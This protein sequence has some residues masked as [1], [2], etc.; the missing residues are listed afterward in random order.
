MTYAA[1]PIARAHPPDGS[2]N[3]RY[4]GGRRAPALRRRRAAPPVGAGA[5]RF[6]PAELQRAWERLGTGDPV[7]GLLARIAGDEARDARLPMPAH[8]ASPGAL[9]RHR[10]TL[11]VVG[12][13]ALLALLP[14]LLISVFGGRLT[15][16]EFVKLTDWRELPGRSSSTWCWPRCCGPST[17]GSP[18]SSSTSSPAS[19]RAASS[20]RPGRAGMTPDGFLQGV[21]ATLPRRLARGPVRLS[22]GAWLAALAAAASVATL[23]VWP[24]TALPPFDRLFAEGDLYWW[25]VVPAYFW[26]VWLPL[27]FVNVYMLVWIVLRQTMMIANIQRL[28][29][30]FAVEPVPYHPDRCSGFAPIGAYATDV[31]RVALII[32]GWALALLLSG[33]ATGHGLYVAPHALFLVVVQVLLTPYLLL[34]PVWYAHRVMGAARDRALRRVTDR[35]RARLVAGGTRTGRRAGYRE[36]EAEYRLATEG[37]HTWPFRPGAFGGVGVTA[38]LTL[39]V[40]LAALFYRLLGGS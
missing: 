22:R 40:N 9:R 37:Y 32:G 13:Y 21:G 3:G 18:A 33:A 19:P 16:R 35:I 7:H 25:R 4:G 29:R 17:C 24:P 8:L 34:G 31:V 11:A 5:V 27:V 2:A 12:L 23:V 15:D 30:L 39:V 10:A 20:A 1:G 38:G 36:L 6:A 28:L 26:G 14:G